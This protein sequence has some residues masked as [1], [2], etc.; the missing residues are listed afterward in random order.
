MIFGNRNRN[1]V[2]AEEAQRQR[3]IKY[4]RVFGSP[5][6]QEVL[7]DILNSC[8]VL[9]TRKLDDFEQGKRSVAL[10]I[11]T[12]IHMNLADFERLLKGE[13]IE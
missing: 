11:L 3:F 1:Q 13:G 10:K 7:S 8:F 12:D 4:R 2:E 5:E 6:G 9:E